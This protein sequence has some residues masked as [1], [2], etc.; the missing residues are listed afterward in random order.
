M[1][2]LLLCRCMYKERIVRDIP[3]R[4]L[5]RFGKL[6]EKLPCVS[7][8]IPKCIAATLKHFKSCLMFSIATPPPPPFPQ[9]TFTVAGRVHHSREE[10]FT[11]LQRWTEGRQVCVT[12]TVAISFHS[13]YGEPPLQ[14]EVAVHRGKGQWVAVYQLCMCGVCVCMCGVCVCVA[15]VRMCGACAC[16]CVVCVCVC[17]ACVCVVCVCVYGACVCSHKVWMEETELH[18][19]HPPAHVPTDSSLTLDLEYSP[20]SHNWDIAPSPVDEVCRKLQAAKV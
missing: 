11:F 16:A 2:L 1:I 4:S 5:R 9:V 14:H 13:H 10:P 7:V 8:Y 18:Y 3:F 17:V 20:G 19:T 15:C 6:T 12:C